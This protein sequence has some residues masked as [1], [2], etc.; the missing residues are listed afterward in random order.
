MENPVQGKTFLASCCDYPNKDEDRICRWINWNEYGPS[1]P[2]YKEDWYF[3]DETGSYIYG[4]FET[5]EKA[6][7]SL[8]K[9]AS[10]L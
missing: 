2:I 5:E 1:S 8:T 3:I 7:L 10:S 9:Y 4:P 6:K